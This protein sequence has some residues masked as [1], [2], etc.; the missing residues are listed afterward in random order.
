MKNGSQEIETVTDRQIDSG[1]TRRRRRK[2][3]D[4][5]YIFPGTLVMFMC[6]F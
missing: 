4:P 1:R 2:G 6:C 5:E 3:E